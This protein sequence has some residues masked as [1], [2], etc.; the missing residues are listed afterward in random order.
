MADMS[1]CRGCGK[2]V[3]DTAARCPFCGCT[4]PALPNAVVQIIGIVSVSLSLWFG[5]IILF[6]FD[7]LRNYF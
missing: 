3:A 5:Y 2:R 1:N 6:R 4:M 7:T